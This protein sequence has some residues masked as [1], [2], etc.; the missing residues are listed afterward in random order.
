MTFAGSAPPALAQKTSISNETS[1]GS[2]FFTI[3]SHSVP[4]A[5]RDELVA[6]AVVA[7]A[8]A[9]GRAGLAGRVEDLGRRSASSREK[10]FSPLIQATVAKRAPSA[11]ASC[12]AAAASFCHRS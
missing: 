11:F 4:S 7:E 5:D 2:V 8:H 3:V 9:L 12:A 10:S 6:V 1:F